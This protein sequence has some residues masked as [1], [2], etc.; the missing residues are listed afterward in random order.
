MITVFKDVQKGIY[1]KAS[2]K[3]ENKSLLN[4]R[5]IVQKGDIIKFLDV[6]IVSPNGD[7][8]IEKITFEIKPGMHLLITGK[9]FFF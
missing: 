3:G 7:V 6:P 4:Q 5:G 8:L 9:I 2:I 1:Y